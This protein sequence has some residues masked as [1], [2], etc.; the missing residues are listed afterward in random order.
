VPA[1]AYYERASGRALSRSLEDERLLDVIPDTH[2]ASY[3]AYRS[4]RMREAPVRAGRAGREQSGRAGPRIAPASLK[5]FRSPDSGEC[6]S[7]VTTP[8]S[9]VAQSNNGSIM[10][11]G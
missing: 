4:R 10:P 3:F 8:L 5:R 9:L 6:R 2:H 11:V 1:S 7:R